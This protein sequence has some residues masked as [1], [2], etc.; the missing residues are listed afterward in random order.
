MPFSE[1]QEEIVKSPCYCHINVCI[2]KKKCPLWYC[3]EN[4]SCLMGTTR[5]TRPPSSARMVQ[6]QLQVQITRKVCR[7]TDWCSEQTTA[8]HPAG[9]YYC[10]TH[11][12]LWDCV[13]LPVALSPRPLWLSSWTDGDL[14]TWTLSSSFCPHFRPVPVQTTVINVGDP[15]FLYKCILIVTLWMM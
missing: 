1:R 9:S 8:V 4:G 2:Q 3:S 5:S 15:V 7:E 14:H 12:L 11:P 13:L 6:W 10:Y